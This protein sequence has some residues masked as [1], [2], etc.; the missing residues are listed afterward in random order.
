MAKT[1]KYSAFISYSHADRK[2]VEWLHRAL[3]GYRLPKNLAGEPAAHGPAARKMKPF[4]RDRDDLPASTD[5]GGTVQKAL[6]QSEF[7]IVVCSPD[8]ARSA[9][10][11]QEIK[12]F[13]ALRNPDKILCLITGG[14]PHASKIKG[15]EQEECF[16]PALKA[17]AG[18]KGFEP[19]AADAR[20]SG[21]GKRLALLKLVAGIL[22]L[23]LD[24]LVQRDAHRRQMRH[25]AALA[26][27]SVLVVV[28]SVLLF[29]AVEARKEAE[30]ARYD[31]EDK[32]AQAEELVDFMLGDLKTKLEPIGNL[33]IMD[34]IAMQ[35]LGYYAS[36]DVDDLDP[37]S[38]ARRSEVLR[39][40]GEIEHQRGN[41]DLARS[42]FEQA[43]L[44]TEELLSQAPDDPDRIFDHSQSIY[45]LAYTNLRRGDL[46]EAEKGFR[47]YA[48]YSRRLADMDPGNLD[49][50]VEVGYADSNLGTV[51][52]S[53]GKF[54][55]AEEEFEQAL[56]VFET[57][58][59]AAPRPG[60][61]EF[62]L[63]QTFA[64]LSD[65]SLNLGRLT[66][67]RDYRDKEKAIYEQQLATT[68]QNNQI[69]EALL[70]TRLRLGLINA[71]L[72]DE[73]E[74][75]A[76]FDAGAALAEN[77]IAFDPENTWPVENLA[78]LVTE[79][80]E[81]MAGD[82]PPEERSALLAKAIALTTNL[83]ARDDTNPVWRSLYDRSLALDAASRL[84][85]GQVDQAVDAAETANAGLWKLWSE[86][87]GNYNLL[88]PL[89][90]SSLTLAK[91]YQASG[92]P[93]L[94]Q[95]VLERYAGELKRQEVRL[96]LRARD[97][98]SRAL[99]LSGS[100]ADAQQ[101]RDFL[102]KMGYTSPDFRLFWGMD[103]GR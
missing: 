46:A 96:G 78:V 24:R 74:A 44:T 66:N 84:A 85:R 99:F 17:I 35:A 36:I 82:F 48:D 20:P 62:D 65:T 73:V 83:T 21:D 19:I 67:A 101:I 63:A 16:P 69:K 94:A 8:A 60:D 28:L 40:V 77:L 26:S 34:D 30:K 31:A 12:E 53:Q 51:Y 72:G 27:A 87:T 45:W 1:Y 41:L 79:E 14:E 43:F 59:R 64:W 25:A 15:R 49:W 75:Q 56:G 3:E 4:F 91:A 80:L 6:K 2:V 42:I 90:Y 89:G 100:T 9:W 86:S 93:G 102:L 47:D 18:K 81:I 76:S 13:A 68:P 61:Y 92:E 33:Q 88:A 98:L 5:L 39:M 97:Y 58:D 55:E 38:L 70:V 11:N 23:D 50:Q 37:E 71:Y 95:A 103:K 57:L 32:R 52:Y 10:V 22:G 7:L 54:A 29:L